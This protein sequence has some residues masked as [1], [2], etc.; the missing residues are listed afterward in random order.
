MATHNIQLLLK[1]GKDLRQTLSLRSGKGINQRIRAGSEGYFV[2]IDQETGLAPENIV[3]RRSDK[4]LH[5]CLKGDSIDAPTVIIEEFFLYH[6]DLFGMGNTN[7]VPAYT[8]AEHKNA[9][10][11]AIGEYSISDQPFFGQCDCH[12]SL[13]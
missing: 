9:Y 12:T 7:N 8:C 11:L 5:V 2:L 6:R 1:E 4:H 3:L 10:E 13:R